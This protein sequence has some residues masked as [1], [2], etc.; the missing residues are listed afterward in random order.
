MY[1]WIGRKARVSGGNI[2]LIRKDNLIGRL[3]VAEKS[4]A[5]PVFR[6]SKIFK[7][8]FADSGGQRAPAR[9]E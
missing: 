9:Q 3:R 5:A 4:S 7:T 6:G 2:A 8:I 1:V